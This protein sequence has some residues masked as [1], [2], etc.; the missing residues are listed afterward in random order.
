MSL[1]TRSELAQTDADLLKQ[2]I[3]EDGGLLRLDA[4]LVARDWIAPGRRLGLV[5]DAYDVGD[6]GAICERWLASTTRADNRV[7]PDREGISRIRLRSGRTIDLEEAIRGQGAAIMG[8]QYARSHDGLGRLAKVY[9]FGS[10]IPMHIHPPADQA[11]LVGRNSKDES[12]YFPAGPDLGPHPETFFG[13][14]PE[15]AGERGAQAI[16]EYLQA[17]TG[18]SILEHSPA[19]LQTPGSGYFVSSGILHA[20][21]TALTVELQEDADTMAFLQASND[22][23]ELSKDLLFKDITERDRAELGERAVLRWIDWEANGDRRFHQRRR[24][25]PVP[26]ASGPGYREEWILH[27]SPKF[28][29]KLLTVEPGVTVHNVERG[30]HNLL[31]WSGVGTV[32]SHDV[33]GWTPDEDEILVTADGAAGYDVSNTGS[34]PMVVFKFFGPD[35]N[36]DSPVMEP[37]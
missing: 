19:Y 36:P 4:A 37:L 3:G 5:E 29:G 28:S 34:D 26:L 1:D 9:D 33:R 30:V 15:L 6:R 7:G 18:D 11:A 21:G 22:G 17:W 14:H 12:S 31:V 20:P 32:G 24:I 13:V 23:V 16:L 10:R 25:L 27:G 8:E 35:L 2:A